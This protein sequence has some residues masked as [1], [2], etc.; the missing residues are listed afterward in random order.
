MEYGADRILE[1][2]LSK[3]DRCKSSRKQS[4]TSSKLHRN[5]L[6]TSVLKAIQVDSTIQGENLMEYR[7]TKLIDMD[8]DEANMEICRKDTSL[9]KDKPK[10]CFECKVQ[11]HEWKP[12]ASHETEDPVENNCC[13]LSNNCLGNS[14]S[15]ENELT[16]CKETCTES[17]NQEV[18]V[19]IPEKIEANRAVITKQEMR[20]LSYKRPRDSNL[21]MNHIPR[22]NKIFKGYGNDSSAQIINNN[23]TQAV[24]SLENLFRDSF[25]DLMDSGNLDRDSSMYTCL[26]LPLISV[27]AC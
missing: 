16:F 23:D 24:S 8:L 5:L 19:E 6:V 17:K 25:N 4:S 14:P 27:M 12:R 15:N 13:H 26:A 10:S 21:D 9:L 3:F 11:N 2:S 1:I 18:S 7:E 22:P 20:K